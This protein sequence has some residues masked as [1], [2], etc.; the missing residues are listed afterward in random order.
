MERGL[1]YMI[2]DDNELDQLAIIAQASKYPV[3]K[4]AGTFSNAIDALA[5]VNS[6]EPDLIFLDI[7]MPGV[8]GIELLRTL[9]N[10]VPVAVFITSHGEYALE[11][12]E[13]DAFDYI[14]KPLTEKR[15][16]DT[17]KRITEYWQMKHDAIA[18]SVQYEQEA[19]TIKEGHNQVRIPI[20]D[21]V[22]LE[23]MD[24]YTKLVLRDKK[25][26]T[27]TSLSHMLQQLPEPKFGRIHRSYAV[28]IDKIDEIRTGE[29]VCAGNE[30]PVG[31]TYRTVVSKWK[32]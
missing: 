23:A 18:Y 30:L 25:Y 21:I 17:M 8:S 28:S 20:N 27:L 15:F 31:K 10:K 22:Y 1:R 26:M 7:D 32:I 3:L 13:L 24:S 4:H 11:G 14:L 12:F 6:I 19:I 16:A 29:L 5:A 9:K 2:A